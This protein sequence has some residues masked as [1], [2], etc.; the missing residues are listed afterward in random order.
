MKNIPS[1]RVT[2]F[3]LPANDVERAWGFYNRVFGWSSEDA[4]EN[5]PQL[6]AIH[7]EIAQRNEMLQH[8]RIIIRVDDVEQAL[9]RIEEAGGKVVIGRT[10]IPDIRMVYASFIDTEDNVVNI[11]GD[12]K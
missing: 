8:P 3:Q 9:A 11:V 5:V 1:N 4:Y 2:W 10:D 12:M 6:G 7:G